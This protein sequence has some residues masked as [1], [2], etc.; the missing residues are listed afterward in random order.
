[1]LKNRAAAHYGC[2]IKDL[3]APVGMGAGATGGILYWLAIFP[4]AAWEG[5]CKLMRPLLAGDMVSASL[6][7][8]LLRPAA[9]AILRALPLSVTLQHF[10]HCA[11]DVVKSAM[12]TDSIDPAHRKYPSIPVAVRKLWA[13]GES[14]GDGGAGN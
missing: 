6:Q 3:S 12:M 7:M 11:V 14:P 1:M 9:R 13:E 10:S 2:E 4:G 5:V 8:H